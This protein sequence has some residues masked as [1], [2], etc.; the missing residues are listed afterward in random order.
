MI[1]FEIPSGLAKLRERVRT[2]VREQ[3]VPYEN[4]P[5]QGPHGPTDE[6]RLELVARAKA[7]GLLSP[8][9]PS[10]YGGMGLDHRGIAVVFE[11][12]GWR[13]TFTGDANPLPPPNASVERLA[14]LGV[15]ARPVEDVVRAY[16]EGL[17][18]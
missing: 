1:D 3:I 10:A 18:A 13:V 2:F 15:R 8:H 6:L 12:A 11:A 17:L 5:R 7:E 9:A 16:L 14:A 4:D